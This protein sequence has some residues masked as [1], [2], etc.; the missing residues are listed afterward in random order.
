MLEI[1][2]K[3]LEVFKI[4]RNELNRQKNC[5]E[6]IASENFVS[7]AVLEA[8]G[9]VLT[10]KYAEGYPGHRYYCGCENVDEVENLGIERAKK[11][12][13]CN[14]VNLQPHSGSTANQAVFMAFLNP[15]DTILGMDLSCGGHLTHGAKITMS[16]KWFNSITYGVNKETELVDYNEIL[17]LAK[18]HKPKLI[19]AGFSAYSRVLDWSKFREIADEVGAILM[20]DMAHIAGL[21]AVN[22]Y[23]SPL[24]YADVVTTTTHKTLRGPRGGMIL[25]RTDKYAKQL[26]SAVFPG[27]QGGP[28]MHIVAAKTV[29]FGEILQPEFKTYIQQVKKNVKIIC[30]ELKKGGLKIVSNDTDCHLLVIDLRNTNVS[31]KLLSNTLEKVGITCNQNS[32]PF[33]PLPPLLTSGVR[34]GTPAITIRGLK[35]EDCAKIARIVVDVFNELNSKNSDVRNCNL[36]LNNETINCNKKIV[37]EICQKYELY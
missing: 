16:G 17:S 27:L 30:D 13:N 12:F 21:V 4:I 7:Q 5:L 1:E 22:E 2:K 24:P 10:N 14:Y 9:S 33:D 35:E 32:V 29:A 11:I 3:D 8:Q 26:N 18:Q 6:L 19:I 23:P 34:L 37:S 25:S 36:E 31:G 28:L 15:G 20:A